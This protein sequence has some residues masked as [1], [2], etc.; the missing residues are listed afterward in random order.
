MEYL[1]LLF[2]IILC[3]FLDY[4]KNKFIQKIFAFLT[5]L[6][7]IFFTG[8]RIETGNDWISYLEFFENLNPEEN[9]VTLSLI[10]K[11]EPGYTFLN[12]IIKYL[13][14]S[15]NEV[16]LLA[17]FITIGFIG[18]SIRKYTQ[19]WFI[20]IL[21]YLRYSYFQT[22][23]MFVRQGIALAIFLYS[24]QFIKEK[25][26]WKYFFLIIIASLFHISAIILFP[27][28]FIANKSFS[29]RVF[30]ILLFFSFIL[31][32]LNLISFISIHIPIDSIKSSVVGYVESD[33]WGKSSAISM[34][35]IE[36]L[37]IVIFGIYCYNSL[38][39][40]FNYFEVMFILYFVGVLIY[41]ISFNSYVFAERFSIYF[42]VAA[43][44]L[45]TYYI[46][47]F[48]H[49]IQK[50]LYHFFLILF[51]SIYI[52]KTV[53]VENSVYL[54]YKSYLYESRK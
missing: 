10:A 27:I 21:L 17:S 48:K 38:K 28:Y 54:P 14:G 32:P 35:T 7:L 47:F 36:R 1:I 44:F 5:L 22:N 24:I 39:K 18:I 42:N 3:S 23:M 11:F 53:Y 41:F 30:L 34:S 37:G 6:I 2:I 43:M 19:L 12:I 15:L 49:K 31:L 40:K 50:I 16:F 13:G 33:V 26:M 52:I 46:S 29:K 51:V 25:K 9:L 8:T 4:S 20:P 45:L